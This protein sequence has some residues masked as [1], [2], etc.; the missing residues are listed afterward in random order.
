MEKVEEDLNRSKSLRERQ[1]KDFSEQLAALRQR[2]EQQV[3]LSVRPSSC[4]LCLCVYVSAM[5]SGEKLFRRY[6]RANR[7]ASIRNNLV[8][9]SHL[10]HIIQFSRRWSWHALNRARIAASLVS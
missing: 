1:A 6:L 2:Y 4:P 10:F 5:H 8:I 9:P 7:L 3:R